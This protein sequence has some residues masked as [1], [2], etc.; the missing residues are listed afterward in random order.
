MG[1][2]PWSSAR[3][4][5]SVGPAVADAFGVVLIEQGLIAVE[6]CSVMPVRH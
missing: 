1:G 5:M 3:F 6:E 2:S 4:A